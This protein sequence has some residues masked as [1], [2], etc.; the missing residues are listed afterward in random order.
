[1]NG[2]NAYSHTLASP[3]PAP[4][5]AGTNSAESNT[6]LYGARMHTD[7]P[8]QEFSDLLDRLRAR[9]GHRT[10]VSLADKA[11]ISH[12]TL[13]SWRSGRQRPTLDNIR[14][15][16]KV[17]GVEPAVLAQAAGYDLSDLGIAAAVDPDPD[18]YLDPETGERYEDPDEREIWDLGRVRPALKRSF[19]YQLR[20]ERQ[21]REAR[22]IRRSA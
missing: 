9:S 8:V 12:S 5:C 16:A 3:C 22:R 6:T 11:E 19:I 21:A 4:V 1:M 13:S 7:W 18:R 20:A 15:V 2:C 10:L 17:L 14:K